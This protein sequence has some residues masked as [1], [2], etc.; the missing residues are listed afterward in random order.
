MAALAD[1]LT[2]TGVSGEIFGGEFIGP[3]G[4]TVNGTLQ[5]MVCD[6]L[7]IHVGLGDSWNATPLAWADLTELER[8]SAY[9]PAYWL[10]TSV[11]S[12]TGLH[13]A[14]PGYAGYASLV[15]YRP[16]PRTSSQEFLIA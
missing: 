3:Y 2:L 7:Y 13:A 10:T 16:N 8:Q 14:N 12:G 1:T 9:G 6:D 11:L 4:V 15:V 5:Q